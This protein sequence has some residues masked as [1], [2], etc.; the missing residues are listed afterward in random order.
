MKR[1]AIDFSDDRL[2]GLASSL[3]DEHNYI[4]ALKILNKNA[5]LNYDD[6]DSYR[7]YAEIFDDIGLAE[8]SINSWF[9]CLDNEPEDLSEPY[10]GLAVSYMSL[11]NDEVAAY[12]Y[13]KLLAETED[14]SPETRR[15]IV[16]R[17]FGKSPDPLKFAYP[18]K[19]ADYSAQ[20]ER[21]VQYMREREYDKA[22]EQ[23][24]EVAE[25][26]P[27]YFAARNYIAMCRIIDSKSEEA[28][29]E[30]MAI[31]Q[32]KPD[33]VQALTTLAAVKS[34]QQLF[35][36]SAALARRLLALNVTDQDDIYKIATVCCENKMHA[37]AYEMFCKLEGD[38]RYDTTVLYFKAISAYNCG[39][40]RASYD[41]FDTL[42]TIEPDAVVARYY[43]ML[44]R[45][46]ERLGKTE[47]FSYFYGLPQNLREEALDT[48]AHFCRLSKRAALK[49]A[50]DGFV[51][52]CIKWAFDELESSE[53]NQLHYVAALCAVKGG[54]DDFLRD[55]LLNAFISDGIKMTVLQELCARNQDNQFGI[56]VCNIYSCVDIYALRLG[57]SK[58]KNFIMAYAV[59]VSRFGVLD[60]DYSARF[61]GA[62]E[63]LYSALAKA[64]A[65]ALS[66]D[67]HAL[68]AAMFSLSSVR[69]SA[70]PSEDVCS[71]FDA[72]KATYQAIM[73]K[74]Q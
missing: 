69:E 58:R 5:E 11:D 22:V 64:S 52:D 59:L 2:I 45:E 39:N 17:F 74:T 73:E 19:L 42:L 3:I 13:N 67:L 63:R 62:A 27:R 48:L 32:K 10:E 37:E 72:D 8:R 56:V 50:K 34:E 55:L 9:R 31:L 28:E 15:D 70:V 24:E 16:E 46:N 40:F 35:E 53:D 26:N 20:M 29:A 44:A 60:E 4:G 49:N 51:L 25:G 38:M 68:T 14:M 43:Y 1:T 6:A 66:D 30:C 7:L 54:Y 41:A 47:T 21:G 71:F 12:Y 23:F 61:C 18:P 33:D 36:E 65:L 57:R